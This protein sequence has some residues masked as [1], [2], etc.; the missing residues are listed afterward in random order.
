MSNEAVTR[1]EV[2]P[3]SGSE[4]LDPPCKQEHTVRVMGVVLLEDAS[5]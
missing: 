2:E 1:G 3:S 5:G 4:M